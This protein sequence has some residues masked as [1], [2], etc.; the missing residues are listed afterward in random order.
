[1]TVMKLVVNCSDTFNLGVHKL[2]AWLDDSDIID[3]KSLTPMDIMNASSIWC[4]AIFSWD[5][6]A[7]KKVSQDAAFYGKPCTVGGPAVTANAQW[8]KDHC[9][10]ATVHEGLHDC[11]TVQGQWPMVWTSRGCIRDCPWCI[12]PKIEGHQMVEYSELQYAPLILDNNF[13]ACSE[14]HQQKVLEL[15]SGKKVDFN[16]GL[17]ARLYSPAFR[18]EVKSHKVKSTVWRFAYD[19]GGMGKHVERAIDDLRSAG[20]AYN[21]IRI[22][23]L[24]NHTEAIDEAVARAK[25][26][27]EWGA[28]PW[29]MAYKPL[30]WMSKDYYISPQWHRSAII[31]FRRFFSRGQLWRSTTWEDYNN[32]DIAYVNELMTCL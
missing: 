12:V 2:N 9:Y 22:Y 11:D 28:S 21:N 18:K 20:I 3:A 16:Q 17:D 23:L 30:D 31:D 4:S 29:P 25:E 13:L 32:T 7:L 19:S 8:I 1:M 6:P 24:F 26:I 5:L 15:W 27:I 10:G 14:Q